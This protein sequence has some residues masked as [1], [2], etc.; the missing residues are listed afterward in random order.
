MRIQAIVIRII[1]Q[2]FRDKRTL[3]LM[4][5]APLLILTLMYLVFHTDDYVPTIAVHD[6]PPLVQE[7]LSE[8]GASLKKK[9]PMRHG[10]KYKKARSMLSS[11]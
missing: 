7:K 5:L 4:L 10:R 9:A 11:H 3:A 1:Q 6:V 2:F 8:Q